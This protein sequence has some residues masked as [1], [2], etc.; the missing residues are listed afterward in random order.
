MNVRHF[1]I[2]LFFP[3]SFLFNS[4]LPFQTFNT[5]SSDHLTASGP[6]S[7]FFISPGG[8]VLSDYKINFRGSESDFKDADSTKIYIKN[9]VNFLYN[10][11][12]DSAA[13]QFREIIRIKPE[14]PEGYFYSAMINWYQFQTF[15][16]KRAVQD[17]LIKELN[18]VIHI[19]EE[20]LEKN[21]DNARA[22]LFLG[23]AHGFK[24]RVDIAR[25]K[26]LS[27]F[28]SGMKGYRLI[29]KSM[30]MDSTLIDG[31]LGLG[32]F[33]YYVGISSR[34][35]KIV[36][37]LFNIRGTKEQGISE[38][39]LV[40][41][42]GKFGKTEAKSFLIFIYNYIEKDYEKALVLAHELRKS[43]PFNPY[44]A[45]LCSDIYLNLGDWQ[46]SASYASYIPGLVSKFPEKFESEWIIRKK[47]LDAGVYFLKGEYDKSERLFNELIDQYNLELDWILSQSYLK[48]G[49]VYDAEGKRDKAKLSYRKVIEIDSKLKDYEEAKIYLKKPYSPDK[50]RERP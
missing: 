7:E 4:I 16:E 26:W 15:G 37:S 39:E 25:K 14:D 3:V 17:S 48:L 13:I 21:P 36:A 24:G 30:Q 50:D 45:F 32:I 1:L 33:H 28:F 11:K 18:K 40:A 31:Y 29:K 38:L 19:A 6:I 49:M 34:F 44:F 20:F 47:Y 2:P 10:F 8:G 23:A 42:K 12:F 9:G 46:K 41:K 35:L 43:Y 27:A 22:V 5:P